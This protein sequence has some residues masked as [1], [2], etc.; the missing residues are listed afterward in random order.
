MTT[1]TY[2]TYD[3]SHRMTSQYILGGEAHYY[4]YNE[5]NM[6]AS[7]QDVGGAADFMRYFV[8]NGV[9]ERVIATD[10]SAYP[11][12][13]AYWSYHGR[14]FLQDKQVANTSGSLVL[15]NYRHNSTR[16][17]HPLGR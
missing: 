17:D 10:N 4:G 14:K 5:R 9:G 15:T 2:Y 7:I 11:N 3:K 12:L 13:P 1:N 16:Q 6:V 8:Y